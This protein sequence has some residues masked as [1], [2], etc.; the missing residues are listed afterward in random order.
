MGNKLYKI[1]KISTD[2]IISSKDKNQFNLGKH[3]YED[4]VMNGEVVSIMDNQVLHKIRDCYKDNNVSEKD[5]KNIAND[6]VNIIVP[7]D[8]EKEDDYC[9]I[10]KAGFKI[11]DNE[12]TRF[13]SGS[14]QIRRNTI[15]FIRKELYSYLFEALCCGLTEE[16]FGN[17]FN[18][19][20]FN[21]YFGL[22]MS[23]CKFLSEVP[24]VCV[25]SD[26]EQ[27]RPHVEVDY[28]ET[29]IQM[30]NS[31]SGKG[32]GKKIIK[33]YPVSKF[34][35]EIENVPALN[36]FDGQGLVDSDYAVK[37]AKD[38]GYDYVPSQFIIRAPWIKGLLVNFR[39]KDYLRQHN[40]T[41]LKDIDGIPM[42]VKDID[43]LIS[44]SQWKM[45]KIYSKKG[46]EQ[47]GW[48][49]YIDS[50]KK[51]NLKW[52]VVMPN[53]KY[54][55]DIKALNYQYNSALNLD[56]NGL[57]EL[58]KRTEELLTNLCSGN[59]EQVYKSLI[60][61]KNINS[62]VEC[63]G[64]D[65]DASDENDKKEYHPFLQ[66]AV[67]HNIDLLQDRYIQDLIMKD[68]KT[69]FN[70]AKIGKLLTESNYQF[71]VSDP[72]AQVQHV[73]KNHA[74]KEIDIETGELIPNRKEIILEEV[75]GLLKENEV[76]SY[77]WNK[78]KWDDN[79]PRKLVLMRSPLIDRSEVVVAD[80]KREGVDWYNT[81]TSGIILSIW[82]LATL[83]MQ[84]CDY[85]GD[86]CY[87]SRM[88]T[89]ITASMKN[90]RPLMYPSATTQLMAT[91]NQE[92][93]I[94]ADIRGLNSKVGSISNKSAAF[95][96]M[97]ALYGEDSEEYN[98]LLSRIK[99]LGEIVGVEIDKIKTG[100][101]PV[102]PT[103]WKPLQY[104]KKQSTDINGRVRTIYTQSNEEKD[105][106]RKHN[107]MIP[108]KKPY[109]MRYIYNYL[110]KDIETFR[111][112]LNQESLY[113][114]GLKIDE[115]LSLPFD[116]N[117]IDNILEK[118]KN[119]I[120]LNGDEEFILS[121]W[122]TKSKYERYF[123]VIDSNCIMNK[124]C[125]RF[126]ELERKFSS[127]NNGNNMLKKYITSSNYD[128]NILAQIELLSGQYSQFKKFLTKN[129]NSN[130]IE[131]GKAI[132]KNT[133]E[134][135]SLLYEHIRNQI[136]DL[137]NNDV[138]TTFDYMVKATGNN[139]TNF[140][141]DVLGDRILE[142]IPNKPI[143]IDNVQE[144]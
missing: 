144:G 133:K 108:D 63:N 104:E 97:L 127:K 107:A 2:K 141:W 27:I 83:Q 126:E 109:F 129:N 95:Y 25:I 13:C 57:D 69:K 92:N 51:N 125:H 89:L 18:V 113:S 65:I 3:S 37:M 72:V 11:N 79:K 59:L 75:D 106:I 74:I 99:I 76:Y 12:Y 67:T 86:R 114:Y 56:D 17:D 103:S 15:T 87:S 100:V 46:G 21:A 40:V 41:M 116:E 45:H 143:A 55:D 50:M 101:A 138:Q 88:D 96:A 120:M 115:L 33:K 36:S 90:P 66:K 93:C 43:I 128:L 70:A 53:K 139:D 111:Y 124:I 122:R 80:L 42:R 118:Q 22:N 102:E 140:V 10:A 137:C 32:R 134:R 110:N 131:N 54:D 78:K 142:V 117:L 52:G 48:K 64:D 34:Y 7:M 61:H 112:S 68:C 26:F 84:N 28:I 35:D 130:S 5:I 98:E 8:T 31:K 81:I 44:A 16:D 77:Y 19:A 38:L 62:D 6:L 49:Y 23:G 14:G 9:V 136:L 47:G 94:E 30:E 58:C 73:I 4:A 39:W 135:L 29:D 24:R 71:L 20:K 119:E 60:I 132:A 85:D 121:Q 91:I 105:G 82:D 123:P 1:Y